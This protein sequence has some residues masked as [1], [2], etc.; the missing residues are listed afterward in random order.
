MVSFRRTGQNMEREEVHKMVEEANE[1]RHTIDFERF[2]AIVRQDS[3]LKTGI[4][5]SGMMQ[6]SGVAEAWVEFKNRDTTEI[7][8]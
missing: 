1:G 6:T 8:F 5:T 7:N 4:T 3:Q 2:C